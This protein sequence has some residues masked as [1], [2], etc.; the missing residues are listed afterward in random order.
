MAALR[1]TLGDQNDQHYGCTF[2]ALPANR[3]G[4]I[5]DSFIE[6]VS[7]FFNQ[8]NKLTEPLCP[9][10][11]HYSAALLADVRQLESKNVDIN[12]AELNALIKDS[13]KDKIVMVGVNLPQAKHTTYS[14]INNYIPGVF[15][16]AAALQNLIDKDLSL[17]HI[18]EPTR[19]Y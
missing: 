1:K 19:P 12:H 17:I 18:S 14:P 10:T 5:K 11:M 6:Y 4:R 16:H 2:K 9:S 7:S 13:I 3:A 15:L 8:N